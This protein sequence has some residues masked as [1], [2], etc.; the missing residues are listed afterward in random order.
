MVSPGG[1]IGLNDYLIFD[2]VIDEQPYGTFQAVNEFLHFN[3]NW[4][5]DALALHSIGFND[6]YL[7]RIF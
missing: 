2:G 7:R 1:I 5:V 4:V 3:K 6:I